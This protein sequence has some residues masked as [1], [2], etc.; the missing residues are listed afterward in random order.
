MRG[1]N[2]PSSSA[3]CHPQH[4]LRQLH[5]SAR[6]PTAWPGVH[7]LTW[8]QRPIRP[9]RLIVLNAIAAHPRN[10]PWEL[11]A[12][13]LT[14]VRAGLTHY[15]HLL[16]RNE[17]G[18]RYNI[19]MQVR[20]YRAWNA[21]SAYYLA[22]TLAQQLESGHDYHHLARGRRASF[23]AKSPSSNASCATALAP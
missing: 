14:R 2:A 22:R 11:F 10:A 13:E 8:G 9:I 21:R 18:R 5:P 23:K 17:Q 12:S 4:L 1:C 15:Q 16:A 7:D 19:E 20:R 3:V 6:R